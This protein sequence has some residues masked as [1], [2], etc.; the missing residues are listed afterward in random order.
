MVENHEMSL[1][2]NQDCITDDSSIRYFDQLKHVV[3]VKHPMTPIPFPSSIYG[4]WQANSCHGYC[5]HIP[6]KNRNPS[7]QLILC[8]LH[9]HLLF[10]VYPHRRMLLYLW[11]SCIYLP[12]FRYC[13]WFW[14]FCIDKCWQILFMPLIMHDSISR[15]VDLA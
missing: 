11:F 2:S 3:M 14:I 10:S 1:V 12:T 9:L 4:R 13:R 5:S 6:I 15:Y 8:I 7:N